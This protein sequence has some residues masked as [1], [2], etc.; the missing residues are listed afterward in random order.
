[1]EKHGQTI[2]S[3][4]EN[5]HAVVASRVGCAEHGEVVLRLAQALRFAARLRY[6]HD[7]NAGLLG[8]LSLMNGIRP[9]LRG[10]MLIYR[11]GKQARAHRIGSRNHWG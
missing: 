4:E 7:A 10:R 2:A 9:S 3:E 8:L 11:S 5:L 6:S 1:M